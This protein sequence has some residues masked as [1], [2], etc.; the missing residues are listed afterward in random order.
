[1]LLVL[2]VSANVPRELTY[3]PLRTREAATLLWGHTTLLRKGLAAFKDIQLIAD[4]LGL[5]T[6]NALMDVLGD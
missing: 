5:S 3:I 2:T 1:M 4:V 6:R